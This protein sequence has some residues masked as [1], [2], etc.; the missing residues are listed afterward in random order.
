MH[1]RFIKTA[2][3]AIFMCMTHC[4]T[5]LEMPTTGGETLSGK[6]VAPAE[7]VRGHVA[8]LVAGF[9]REAGMQS[10]TWRKAVRADA[11]LNGIPVYELA[12]LEKAPGIIRGMIK[13]GMRKGVTPSDQD[14][15]IVITQDQKLWEKFFGVENDKDSYV[16]LLD[17]KGN[18]IWHGHGPAER[19]EPLLKNALKQ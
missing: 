5:A 11:G 2:I 15:I 19:L 1:C 6:R 13:S 12:M 17:A 7:L 8:I 16:L 18:V 3:V 4:C 10:G 14:Q 9:S